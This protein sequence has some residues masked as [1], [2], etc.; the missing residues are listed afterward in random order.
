MQRPL[1]LELFGENEFSC[2]YALF[3]ESEWGMKGVNRHKKGK[4]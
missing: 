1:A 4:A 3:E 2:V